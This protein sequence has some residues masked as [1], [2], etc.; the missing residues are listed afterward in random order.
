[1]GI[2]C[3]GEAIADLICKRELDSPADADQFRPHFGG[4]LANVAVAA[5]R[6]GAAA[7]LAGGVGDD[8]MGRW[9]RDRLVAE[10]V[11]IRWFNVLPG[12]QTPLALTTFDAAR[13]PSFQIY[14][15]GLEAGF[16]SV[17]NRISEAVRSSSALLFGSN[18]LVEKADPAA[19]T[20]GTQA[21]LG[22]GAL[23]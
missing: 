20:A 9:L 19:V 2:L 18:T 8:P 16:E 23:G 15:D 22:W 12:V 5:R 4:A 7:A 21:C 6:H 10:G 3:L 17:A 14:G 1:M 11:D 13:E